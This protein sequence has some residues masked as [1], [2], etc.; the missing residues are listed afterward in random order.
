MSQSVLWGIANVQPFWPARKRKFHR[1]HHSN[2]SF[3]ILSTRKYSKHVNKRPWIFKL[4]DH[5]NFLMKK[6]FPQRLLVCGFYW[7]PWQSFFHTTLEGLFWGKTLISGGVGEGV[8]GRWGGGLEDFFFFLT[9]LKG[10]GSPSGSATPWNAKTQISSIH[11][12]SSCLRAGA[13]CVLDLGLLC[14]ILYTVS[15]V[16]RI[17]PST[18]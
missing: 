7:G 9:K 16:Y 3:E 1:A 4:L 17:R 2:S 15:P 10:P 12:N 13:S 6:V 18:G 11:K 14:L 8:G 5:S